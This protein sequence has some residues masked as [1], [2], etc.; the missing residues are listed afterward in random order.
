MR[1]GAFGG[2]LHFRPRL[3]TGRLGEVDYAKAFELYSKSALVANAE[4][5]L[6]AARLAKLGRVPNVSVQEA[7]MVVR[8]ALVG[9]FQELGRG[10]CAVLMQIGAVYAS[11]E[12][13]PRSELWLPVV[14]GR[15]E[16]RLREGR[17]ILAEY[18]RTGFGVE[19]S[20]SKYIEYLTRAAEAG[21][22]SAMLQLGSVYVQGELL[23]RIARKRRCGSMEPCAAGVSTG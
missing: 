20:S 1:P 2:P 12:I 13:G 9:M 10:S 19:Q 11:G 5:L 14:P 23:R 22:P 7:D 17:E 3:R 21:L 16:C 18:H 4:G 8:Q 6:A 15:A